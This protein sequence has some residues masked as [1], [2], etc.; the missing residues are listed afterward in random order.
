VPID[1]SDGVLRSFTLTAPN[2]V[3]PIDADTTPSYSITKPDMTAGTAP[4][5]QHGG[6]GDYYVVYPSVMAG[7]HREV[8]TSSVGGIPVV[9]RRQFI[10]ETVD[11]G[12]F[13]D[14]DEAIQHLAAA[15]IIVTP[16]ELDWLRW[17]CMVASD[18]VEK[19]LNRIISPRIITRTV[20]GGASAIVLPGTVQSVT[21]VVEDGITLTAGTDYTFSPAVGVL[22]RGGQQSARSW[23]SGRQNVTITLVAGDQSPPLV[24]RAVG[25]TI[26]A[27]SW[28]MS[29]Q[30]PHPSMDD[31]DAALQTVAAG[32]RTPSETY[33]AYRN[34]RQLAI[35]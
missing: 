14:T 32:S 3:D 19:D 11:G 12:G 20:D 33:V 7:L 1:F 18:A 22:Y 21:S 15:G 34:L 10:V 30:M 6:V 8:L 9:I 27:R 26:V 5:V 23:S 2:G 35:A 13:I 28:Q 24:A 31:V 16:D 25:M 17:L 29:R 4:A